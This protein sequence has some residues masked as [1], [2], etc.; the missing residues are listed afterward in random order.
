MTTLDPLLQELMEGIEVPGYI[1][2]VI[3][4]TTQ[5]CH[6]PSL[7]PSAYLMPQVLFQLIVVGRNITLYQPWSTWTCWWRFSTW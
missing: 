2:D 5:R 6:K 1:L 7:H 3:W 4:T